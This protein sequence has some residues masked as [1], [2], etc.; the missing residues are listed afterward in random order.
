MSATRCPDALNTNRIIADAALILA[1]HDPYA[2]GGKYGAASGS[3]T[4]PVPTPTPAPTPAPAP[5]PDGDTIEDRGHAAHEHVEVPPMAGTDK[6]QED[7]DSLIA[8]LVDLMASGDG[9]ESGLKTTEFWLMVLAVAADIAGPSIGLSIDGNE[10]MLIAAGL[11]SAY[12]AFRSWRK[13]GGPA[14]LYADVLK[15]LAELRH[16][17]A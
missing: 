15:A 11:V 2:A 6:T 4:P 17:A 10:R 9:V 5:G 14:K 3:I 7:V 16:A 1:G 12:G 8:K 13:R